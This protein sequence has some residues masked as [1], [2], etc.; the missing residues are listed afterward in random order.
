MEKNAGMFSSK[1]LISFRLKK[2]MDIFDDIRVKL[3]AKVFWKKWTTPLNMKGDVVKN[4]HTALSNNEGIHWSWAV[5]KAYVLVL[6][7]EQIKIKT[8]KSV[9]CVRLLCF[10]YME[11][12]LVDILQNIIC[13]ST[14]ENKVI[15][16]WNN[17]TVSKWWYKNTKETC[18]VHKIISWIADDSMWLVLLPTI[19]GT[20]SLYKKSGGVD[21]VN[22]N[23]LIAC[24][25]R[26]YSD[27][28]FTDHV[29]KWDATST[30]LIL[31]MCKWLH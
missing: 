31:H 17:V 4:V 26:R 10:H 24:V 14:D 12:G 19:Q 1:T 23:V 8:F 30:I 6:C 16:V 9:C 28:L 29:K 15:R 13:F 3:S 2:D 5:L 7:E 11:N 21:R 22:N 25:S 20:W 27:A 18:I